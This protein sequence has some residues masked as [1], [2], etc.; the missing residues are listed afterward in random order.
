MQLF[1]LIK[2]LECLH[3]NKLIGIHD[4]LSFLKCMLCDYPAKSIWGIRLMNLGHFLLPSAQ[5]VVKTT[6]LC[7][8]QELC[9]YNSLCG[10]NFF[11]GEG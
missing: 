9:E 2:G 6:K 10:Y 5:T 3:I 4:A 8:G 1:F 11:Y 7:N